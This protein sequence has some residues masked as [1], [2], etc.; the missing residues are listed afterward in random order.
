MGNP[1]RIRQIS[2]TIGAFV[3][4][5]ALA[6][7]TVLAATAGDSDDGGDA[8]APTVTASEQAP[9]SPQEPAPDEAP[10]DVDDTTPVTSVAEA[11]EADPEPSGDAASTDD[12]GT[13]DTAVPNPLR[14]APAAGGEPQFFEDFA[15]ESGFHDR[16]DTSV[17]HGVDPLA[18]PDA[19]HEWSGD[20]DM[21]APGRR[22]SGSSTSPS[23][24]SRSGGA[25]RRAPR[26]GT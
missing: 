3:A 7:V 4:G 9:P 23:T 10:V 22:R 18:V 20:H 26:A 13:T 12:P 14:S 5:A 24:P 19:V 17:S 2:I 25:R 8:G 15:E 16:F 1:R 21:A 6:T 11:V